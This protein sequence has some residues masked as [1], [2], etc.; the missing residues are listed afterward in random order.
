VPFSLINLSLSVESKIQ[1]NMY[2]KY[3]Y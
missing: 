1:N 2:V 3:S